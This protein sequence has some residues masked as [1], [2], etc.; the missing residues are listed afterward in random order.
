MALA[1]AFAARRD[2][3]GPELRFVLFDGEEEP[4]GCEDFESCALR[5]SKAYVRDHR[6]EQIQAMILLDYVASK[7]LRLPR[8]GTSDQLLWTIIRNAAKRVGVLKAFPPTSDASLLDDHTAF[9]RERIPAIDL[10]DWQYPYKDT[11]RDTVDKTSARSLDVVGE[12]VA[13]L[14]LHWQR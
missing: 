14:L 11:L 7:R 2:W 9:L 8:E 3:N 6:G 12:T 5:G 10:I 4:A 13:D 1:R